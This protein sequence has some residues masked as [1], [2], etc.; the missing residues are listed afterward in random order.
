VIRAKATCGATAFA[1]VLAIGCAAFA[2]EPLTDRFVQRSALG[3]TVGIHYAL[4]PD[5][6]PGEEDDPGPTLR[7]GSIGIVAGP[8][9]V[10]SLFT[11]ASLGVAKSAPLQVLPSGPKDGCESPGPIAIEPLAHSAYPAVAVWTVFVGKGCAPAGHVFVPSSDTSTSYVSPQVFI[12]LDNPGV[13]RSDGTLKVRRVRT[14]TIP[15]PAGY[16]FVRAWTFA[17]VEGSDASG[18]PLTIALTEFN[19]SELPNQ[20]ETIALFQTRFHHGS[21]FIELSKKHRMLDSGASR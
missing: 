19:Q 13:V 9:H 14:F 17:V 11:L 18:R 7:D 1:A 4:N 16:P 2:A 20:G 15:K 6:H 5:P 10:R 3:I 8:A 12:V 21:P